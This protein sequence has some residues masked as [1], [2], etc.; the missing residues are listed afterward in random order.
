[1]STAAPAPLLFDASRLEALLDRIAARIGARNVVTDAAELAPHLVEGRG[2]YHGTTPAMLKPADT[3]EVA[4]IVSEC[5]AAGV[6]LVPQGGN[7]GLVGGQ[8]PFGAVLLSLARLNRIRSLDS[9]DLTVVAEAGCT[10]FQVQQAAAEKGCLF[11]LSIASEGTCQI[12]GNLSSNA[13]GTA[14]LRYGNMRE[15]A[16]GLEVVLPDGRIWNGL[17]RLRKDN[18]GYDLK[19]VFIGAEGTLGIITAASLR[20]FPAPR[21]RT[22]TFVGL[23]DVHM[24]LALLNRLRNV[25]G[26]ALTGF[27]FLSEFGLA[28]VLKHVPGTTRPFA[29][30]HAF[31][32]LAELTSTRRDDDLAALA[33]GVLGEAFEA[34]EIEDAVIASSEAQSQA[35]WKLRESL[36]EAQK[37]EGGSIKHDVSV[38]VSLVPKFVEEASRLC[39]DHMPGLRPC[40]FGHMGDGNIHFNISQPVGM[41]K[42]AY[43]DTWE[44]FN[45]LVHDLVAS[46]GGSISAE[47]GIGLLKREELRLYKDPV[48]IELMAALK[49]ALDPADLMN[50]GKVLPPE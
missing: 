27:E 16:F 40:P 18:T 8:T 49:K 32:V 10:L 21:Q 43:L 46:M 23:A 41:D 20:L 28:T 5:A 35:L 3:A 11:P 19:D 44:E 7:T 39:V 45:R 4:F 14:V 38:P 24:A 15:L 22:T 2:L 31:Y 13:G 47:H 48:A 37:F 29:G 42:Q 12:G 33:E 6:A 26:D 1:M 30:E 17:S 36:S 34:G 50:P 25:A 9:T